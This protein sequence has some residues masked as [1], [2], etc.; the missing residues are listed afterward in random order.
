MNYTDKIKSFISN[1]S[2]DNEKEITDKEIN[3]IRQQYEWNL[4]IETLM[5]NLSNSKKLWFKTIKSTIDD[6]YLEVKAWQLKVSDIV[7]SISDFFKRTKIMI[8]TGV[9]LAVFTVQIIALIVLLTVGA[10][11]LMN[12]ITWL[13]T[14]LIVFWYASIFDDMHAKLEWKPIQPKENLNEEDKK[15][16]FEWFL[17]VFDLATF[18][19]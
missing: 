13:P 19:Q 17:D 4:F 12:P 7:S 6:L 10:L 18:F 15:T 8:E 5:D 1:F 16:L 14:I 11:I 3:E 2:K 9:E